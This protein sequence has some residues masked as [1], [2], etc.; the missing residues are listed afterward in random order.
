MVFNVLGNTLRLG[1]LLRDIL[2]GQM[3]KKTGTYRL[4]Y[5]HYIIK[6]MRFGTCREVSDSKELTWDQGRLYEV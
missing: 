5:V 6:E 3:W 4:E 2:E 1:G